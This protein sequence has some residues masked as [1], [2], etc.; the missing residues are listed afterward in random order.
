M[1]TSQSGTRA[2]SP[3][4]PMAPL[5]QLQQAAGLPEWE[6]MQCTP[7]AAGRARRYVAS[8]LE[9]LGCDAV[10]ED[11]EQIVTELV[12]NALNHTRCQRFRLSVRR[13]EGWV[14]IG[15][16]DQSHEAPTPTGAGQES[17]SGRGLLM[18]DRL[19]GRWGYDVHPWGKVV[20]ADLA[21]PSHGAS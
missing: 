12:A 20:W 5:I 3:C 10:A 2:P 4:G 11:A 9:R 6:E 15:V 8:A 17:E 13:T 1:T 19:A 7:P 18:V 16:G 14:R 21:V